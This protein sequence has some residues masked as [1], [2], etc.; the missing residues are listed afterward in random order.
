MPIKH[1]LDI[2]SINTDEKCIPLSIQCYNNLTT[3]AVFDIFKKSTTKYKKYISDAPPVLPREG[4]MF[5]Y[6]LGSDET[7]W[8]KKKRKLR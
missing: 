7:L 8:E 5:L 1:Q 3:E 2:Y 6:S 4:Q